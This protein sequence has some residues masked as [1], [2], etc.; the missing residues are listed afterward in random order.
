M[1]KEIQLTIDG[2][3]VVGEI[4]AL[5]LS[6][7]EIEIKEPFGGFKT[8]THVPY[9]AMNQVNHLATMTCRDV[10]ALTPRGRQRAEQLLRSLYDHACGRP[11]TWGAYKRT[12][13]GWIRTEMP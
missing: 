4:L 10:S 3:V 7:L 5:S 8:G 1:S 13:A 12:P 9:F 11:T 6:D 2:V